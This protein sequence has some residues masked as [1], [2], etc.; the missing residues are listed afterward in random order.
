MRDESCYSWHSCIVRPSRNY[1]F[2]GQPTITEV[3]KS[4]QYL[5]HGL[6][7]VHLQHR[8]ISP[9]YN[10]HVSSPQHDA[11]EQFLLAKH[12]KISAM[13]WLKLQNAQQRT[14]H[15]MGQSI[16]KQLVPTPGKHSLHAC[17]CQS[18][19]NGANG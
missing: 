15:S 16:E 5:Q 2:R 12:A 18:V 7:Q 14:V 11:C 8:Q 6:N 9:T 13:F 1:L 19:Q 17:R 3:C 10:S 4:I